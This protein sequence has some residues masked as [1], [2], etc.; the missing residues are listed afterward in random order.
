MTNTQ[1]KIT[2][3]TIK[4]FVRKNKDNLYIKTK[5]KFDGMT[6]GVENYHDQSITKAEPLPEDRLSRH[7]L[8]YKGTHIV[9]S[10]RNWFESVNF[11]GYYGYEIYNCCGTYYVLTK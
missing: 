7:D 10:G 2:L 8:G 4:A 6:D 9:T 1:K 3:S 5:S 11:D